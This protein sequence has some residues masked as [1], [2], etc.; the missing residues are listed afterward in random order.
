MPACLRNQQLISAPLLLLWYSI[1][2]C[3]TYDWQR[4]FHTTNQH[5]TLCLERINRRE[6]GNVH[7]RLANTNRMTTAGPG[8]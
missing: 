3:S 1:A 7:H 4:E 5:Q 6:G 2:D 8:C